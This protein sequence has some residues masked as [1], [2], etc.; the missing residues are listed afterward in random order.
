MGAVARG[1]ENNTP[2]NVHHDV[3]LKAMIVR[4][5]GEG[6]IGGMG[7]LKIFGRYGLKPVIDVGLES[8]TRFNSMS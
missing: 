8:I 6:H 4:P 7:A 1:L 5:L 3:T 2:H